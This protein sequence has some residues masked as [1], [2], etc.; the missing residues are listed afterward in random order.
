MH[1]KSRVFR[2]TM[3]TK[4]LLGY[5][6]F[7]IFVRYGFRAVTMDDLAKEMSISKKTLYQHFN[8]KE[9][10]IRQ[11]LNVYHKRQ[12]TKME[13]IQKEAQNPIEVIFLV[14]KILIGESK[15]VNIMNFL[16]L[17]KYYFD[18][19]QNS[20]NSNEEY[21][22]NRISTN[23]ERGMAIGFYRPDLNRDIIAKLFYHLALALTSQDNNLLNEYPL[24]DFIRQ[25]VT[26]HLNGVCTD[27]GRTILENYI[28]Q[29]FD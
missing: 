9:D 17:K 27:E 14:F 1:I 7:E 26:Y 4:D 18:I 16:D 8:N 28:K 20:A 29:Y 10:V 22:C 11:A 5:K 3:D 23:L 15:D 25:I 21:F 13:N 12:K 19:W 2:F 24:R 6:A